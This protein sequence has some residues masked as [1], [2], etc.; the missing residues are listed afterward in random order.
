MKCPKCGSTNVTPSHKRGLERALQYVYPK[1]P[2]RCKECWSRYWK[3]QS[4]F[5]NRKSLIGTLAIMILVVLFLVL[6]FLPSQENGVS[7]TGPASPDAEDMRPTAAVPQPD[8]TDM[9]PFEPDPV[10]EGS[11]A[12]GPVASIDSPAVDVADPP[13]AEPAATDEAIEVPEDP[14]EVPAPASSPSAET[15]ALTPDA[16]AETVEPPAPE[17]TTAAAAP[18]EAATPPANPAPAPTERTRQ[19]RS[20]VTAIRQL[21]GEDGF[22]MALE[23]SGPIRDYTTFT[24]DSP[25][26]LVI[27]LAGAW[28]IRGRRT[29][30]MEGNLVERIRIGEHP[31][32]LSVV[33]DLKR[34]APAA[35]RIDRTDK[36]F[37]LTLKNG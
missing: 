28:E 4:P 12:A 15:A 23:S 32:Y 26:R 10:P 14:V 24:M 8:A 36:G 35:P 30:P 19:E 7:S 31:Q 6:P 2:Y 22:R 17:E 34:A 37:T 3:L 18:E 13:V 21:A 33:L 27:N 20:R 29:F 9:V 1:V 5:A 25:P 11:D 16:E